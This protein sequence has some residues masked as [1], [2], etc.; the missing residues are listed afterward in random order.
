MKKSLPGNA[1]LEEGVDSIFQQFAKTVGLGLAFEIALASEQGWFQFEI[2][3]KLLMNL[4]ADFQNPINKNSNAFFKV[5]Q[6][7]FLN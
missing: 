1:I 2:T 6:F 7:D 3:S 4:N 5:I